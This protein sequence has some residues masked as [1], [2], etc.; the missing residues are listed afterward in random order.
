MESSFLQHSWYLNELYDLLIGRPGAR[1]AQFTST[2]IDARIID[3]AVNGVAGL[4][5]RSGSVVRRVQTGYVRNYALWIVVG[6]V[7]V[8]AFML[9]RLWWG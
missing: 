2:V 1:L 6:V 4:T 5:R 3:G 7:A 8:F 9:T